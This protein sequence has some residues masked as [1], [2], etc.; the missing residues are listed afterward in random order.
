MSE[1][2][3]EDEHL[4][5]PINTACDGFDNARWPCFEHAWYALNDEATT[6][7]N[8]KPILT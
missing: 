4:N 7:A 1:F 3:R 2:D 5:P 6:P 8:F